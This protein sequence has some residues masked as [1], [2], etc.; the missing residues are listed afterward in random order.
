MHVTGSQKKVLKD[1]AFKVESSTNLI[2]VESNAWNIL[3][4]MFESKYKVEKFPVIFHKLLRSLQNCLKLLLKKLCTHMF[5][6]KFT[7]TKL[8]LIHFQEGDLFF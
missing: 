8:L 4:K 3:L 5:R 1:D 7:R 6:V 2:K